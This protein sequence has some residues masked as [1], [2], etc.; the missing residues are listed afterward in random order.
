MRALSANEIEYGSSRRMVA[1]RI[2]L[3]V[4]GGPAPSVENE[5]LREYPMART[6]LLVFYYL[7]P[8]ERVA[9]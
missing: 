6:K 2:S 1:T 7:L 3:V 4:S 9:A 8:P 5:A